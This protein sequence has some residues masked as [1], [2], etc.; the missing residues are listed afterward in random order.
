[1]VCLP[2]FIIK[3]QPKV[4]KYT[5][6]MDGMGDEGYEGGDHF[7]IQSYSFFFKNLHKLRGNNTSTCCWVCCTLHIHVSL[8]QNRLGI[9]EISPSTDQ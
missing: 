3:N 1:M 8:I 6:P 2:T 9:Q 4:G 5:S 7:N